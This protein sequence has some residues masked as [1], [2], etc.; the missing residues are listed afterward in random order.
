MFYQ[1][2]IFLIHLLFIGPPLIIIGKYHDHPKIKDN[3]TIWNAMF[4]IG[5]SVVVYHSLKLYQFRVNVN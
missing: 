3:K 2:Y 4:L 1:E 5:L